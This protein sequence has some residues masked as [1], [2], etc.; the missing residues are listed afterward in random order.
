MLNHVLSIIDERQRAARPI[1]LFINQS[2][3]AV[4]NT[5]LLPK[6]YKQ[7]QTRGVDPAH[8]V[9]EFKLP[10]IVNRLKSAVAFSK[11]LHKLGVKMSLGGFDGSDTAFQALEHL[12]VQFVKLP[13]VDPESVDGPTGKNISNIVDRLHSLDRL[14]II[15]AI[16]DAKTAAKLWATGVDYIQGNFVQRPEAELIYQF[17]ESHI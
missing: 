3:T 4:G 13:P 16:E 9:L 15:P 12:D 11:G 5:E 6:L 10:E 8:L 17:S 7:L 14:V 2:Q 1:Q